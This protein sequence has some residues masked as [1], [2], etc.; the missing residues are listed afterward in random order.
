[1]AKTNIKS[2][3]SAAISFSIF[4]FL[5]YGYFFVYSK[6]KFLSS[7]TSLAKRSMVMINEK[8]K[9]FEF[10]KSNLDKQNKN[11]EALE[12][13]F[14]SES[15]FV[16]LLNSFE[17]LS[18]KVGVKF[19]A[20]GAKLPELGGEAEISFELSGNFSSIAKFLVLLDNIRYSGAVN[21]F[22]LFKNDEE[23]K[24]LTANIDYLIFS[25]KK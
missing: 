16:D 4:I 8:R 5:T 3:F 9:E 18:K 19:E 14:F 25:Y 1:M 15:G 24:L 17:N 7:E 11:V 13:A 12:S 10:A 2:L 21:K 20:K 22:S 6:I 23:S